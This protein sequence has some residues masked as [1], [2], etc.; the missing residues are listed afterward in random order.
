MDLTD[1]QWTALEPL[2]GEL[3]RRA[4]DRGRPWRDSHDALNGIL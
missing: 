1:E 4:E 2:I 3:P